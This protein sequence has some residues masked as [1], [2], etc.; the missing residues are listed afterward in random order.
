M[1]NWFLPIQIPLSWES[2]QKLPRHPAYRYEF[3]NEE[4]CLTG[5]PILKN[6]RIGTDTG[7]A[8]SSLPHGIELL[9]LTSWSSS[10]L[11]NL[12]QQ[13]FQNSAP[14][15]SLSADDRVRAT[16]EHFL[17]VLRGRSWPVDWRASR[18][19]RQPGSLDPVGA[20]LVTRVPSADW[21]DFTDP[22]W[23]T[24][25]PENAA[26]SGWGLPHLTWLFIPPQAQRQ[27]FA[28]ILLNHART[29]LHTQGDQELYSTI[30]VGDHSSLLWHWKQGF[31]LIS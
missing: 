11:A 10:E 6:C 29:F 20:S 26:E 16:D 12:F 30:L 7:T 18:G 1:H 31:Q 9:P 24:Q 23:Q 17:N 4:V 3:R 21:S 14:F 8:S 2:F 28:T 25:P 22:A 5:R 27:G 13:A 15:A 19:I